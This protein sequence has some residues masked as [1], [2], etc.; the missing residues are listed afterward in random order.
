[1]GRNR[2]LAEA[3]ERVVDGPAAVQAQAQAATIRGEI[4]QPTTFLARVGE[5]P[6]L[7][8]MGL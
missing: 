7:T 6:G 1:M 5:V 4:I 2:E 8:M 3:L